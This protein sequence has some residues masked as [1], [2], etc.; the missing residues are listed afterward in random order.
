M[1]VSSSDYLRLSLA[2][3]VK[4]DF[5]ACREWP[6]RHHIQSRLIASI[7][8]KAF[9]IF[10]ALSVLGHTYVIRFLVDNPQVLDDFI[11]VGLLSGLILSGTLVVPPFGFLLVP[12][13]FACGLIII[14]IPPA[15]ILYVLM[16][17]IL[18]PVNIRSDG[19]LYI[20]RLLSPL[21]RKHS[22]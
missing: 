22:K 7:T 17:L 8:D 4:A 10:L 6:K 13:G 14:S 1:K 18:E 5:R 12:F 21:F 3:K 16:F 2:D 15:Y 20:D 11:E 19:T 9:W